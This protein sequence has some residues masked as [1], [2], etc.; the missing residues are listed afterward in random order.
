MSTELILI[1][2]F[3]LYALMVFLSILLH[4]RIIFSLSAILFIALIPMLDV[5]LLQVVSFILALIHLSSL[6]VN[7]DE[8]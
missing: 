5:F 4:N 2:M 3:V 8:D 1:V 6:F 7:S